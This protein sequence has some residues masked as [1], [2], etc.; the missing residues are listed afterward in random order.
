MRDI[1]NDWYVP[2]EDRSAGVGA[3][4]IVAC[5]AANCSHAVLMDPRP[6]FGA[7]RFWPVSGRSERFRC[8]CGSRETKLSYT[9]NTSQKDG[10]ISADAIRLWT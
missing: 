1:R 10:P 9:V 4:L 3:R 7:R 8:R 6:L 5:E 2:R